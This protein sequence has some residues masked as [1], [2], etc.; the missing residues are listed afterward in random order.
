MDPNLRIMFLVKENHVDIRTDRK[1]SWPKR[2]F[3]QGNELSSAIVGVN[4]DD[5]KCLGPQLTS[6]GSADQG[7]LA[8]SATLLVVA[9][10]DFTQGDT[11]EIDNLYRELGG[12][13]MT[14]DRGR[15]HLAVF[16]RLV[17]STRDHSEATF[18]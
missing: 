17:E 13:F 2:G 4:S 8:K 16:A 18:C 9:P 1:L 6:P 14:I 7:G 10:A 3:A 11:N 15:N 12:C 5:P